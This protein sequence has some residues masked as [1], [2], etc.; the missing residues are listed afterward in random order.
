MSNFTQYS[1]DPALI[2][3]LNAM[4]IQ[5]P[6]PVQAA[7]IPIALK[8]ADVLASAQTGTGKTLAYVIPMLSHLSQNPKHT[9]LILAPT[10]ELAMQVQQTLQRLNSVRV[11]LLIGGTSIFKEVSE[12]RRHPRVIVGTPGR[13]TDH[14]NRKTLSLDATHFLVIDEADRMLDMGFGI[15]LDNIAKFLPE[16]R[17]TLMFSATLPPNMNKLTAKYLKNPERISI[18]ST[19]APSAQVKLENIHVSQ[20]EKFPILLENLEKR[21]GS[22]IVFVKTKRGADKLSKELK[23]YGHSTHAIHGDLSQQR[24]GKVI[25]AFRQQKTRIL[26]ATDV[27]AR[28]LD[29]PHVMHVI[30]YDLPTSP[31]DYI[32]RIG[33]T[34]RAGAEG[35]AM[36]LISPGDHLK[37]KAIHRMMNPSAP[38]QQENP[39][40]PT[41]KQQQRRK[42]RKPFPSRHGKER[43]FRPAKKS[44]KQPPRER[45]LR[46]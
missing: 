14:L 16:T 5:D 18:G 19:I 42:D 39:R 34:G 27:A 40:S 21:E 1:I 29:I 43:G 3:A 33:R 28:G 24:R 46:G 2:E 8:G 10:R 30:N 41:Q 37:W 13:V 45:S 12:L 11:T 4:H 20:E 32:H 38:K 35:H 25:H 26:V 15:Q 6:T 17:Q 7:T 44:F 9:A 22:I 23:E 31:E 36:C